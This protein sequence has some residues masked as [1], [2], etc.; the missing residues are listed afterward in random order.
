MK[1]LVIVNQ[2]KIV[3]GF[4]ISNFPPADLAELLESENRKYLN[5]VIMGIK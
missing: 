5:F 3:K 4:G 1:C 2:E